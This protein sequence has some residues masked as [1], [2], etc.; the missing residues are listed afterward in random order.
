VSTEP[1]PTPDGVNAL[2][3][4]QRGVLSANVNRGCEPQAI[5]PF[6]DAKSDAFEEIVR[7]ACP[8]L[9]IG[10]WGFGPSSYIEILVRVGI[11]LS[12]EIVRCDGPSR[13]S[14]YIRN[15]P[16]IEDCISRLIRASRHEHSR[17]VTRSQ[18][19]RPSTQAVPAHIR[20]PS[21]HP[22]AVREL[23]WQ[24]MEEQR[25]QH[26]L[27]QQIEASLQIQKLREQQSSTRRLA[28]PV[29]DAE[30]PVAPFQEDGMPLTKP[31]SAVRT[32]SVFR[33]SAL[34]RRQ[35]PTA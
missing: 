16:A 10:N 1:T 34:E 15:N 26:L 9:T 24:R 20:T 14:R 5:D 13:V 29:E 23:E 12:V 11:D 17:R 8:T 31:E 25:R 22:D 19:S 28:R 21:P 27:N 32:S 33:K 4:G 7:V 6:N 2:R 18:G 30:L 3:P 35:P